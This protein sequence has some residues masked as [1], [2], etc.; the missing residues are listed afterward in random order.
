MTEIKSDAVPAFSPIFGK[1]V[2]RI[3]RTNM[4]KHGKILVPVPSLENRTI[5]EIVAVYDVTTMDGEEIAPQVQVGDTVLLG[6]YTGT[7]C[8]FGGEDFVICR[9]QDLLAVLNWD[10]DDYDIGEGQGPRISATRIPK[11]RGGPRGEH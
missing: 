6:Q 2:V 9:E 4:R 3:S 7:E 1:V 5:G 10:A 8:H 11:P